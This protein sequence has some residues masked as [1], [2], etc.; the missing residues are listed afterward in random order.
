MTDEEKNIVF[1]IEPHL[2]LIGPITLPPLELLENAKD[3]PPC[4]SQPVMESIEVDTTPT[5]E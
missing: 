1:K 2:F 5:H 4:F 3:Y